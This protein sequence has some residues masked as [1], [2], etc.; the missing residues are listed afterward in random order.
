MGTGVVLSIEGGLNSPPTFEVASSPALLATPD[1]DAGPP[2]GASGGVYSF[3]SL[4]ATATPRTIYWA[5]TFS[6]VLQDCEGP[7]FTFTTPARAL[8]VVAPPSPAGERESREARSPRP[9]CVVPKLTGESLPAARVALRRAHCALGHVS[10]RRRRLGHLV[11]T[12]QSI[13]PGSRRTAG[14][15]VAVRLGTA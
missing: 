9:K 3:A 1:I 7:P 11:V 13:P 4:K 10:P 14:A 6:R 5:V 8:T 2:S 15:K 12:R